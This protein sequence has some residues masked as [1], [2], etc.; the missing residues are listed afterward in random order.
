MRN[1]SFK[2]WLSEGSDDQIKQFSTTPMSVPERNS[3]NFEW[4]V[5]LDPR[6]KTQVI[7]TQ[8][9]LWKAQLHAAQVA[10]G[11]RFQDVEDELGAWVEEWRRMSAVAA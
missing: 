2:E 11:H 10:G 8:F 6:S 1:F 9:N 4:W 3:L 5:N 7:K